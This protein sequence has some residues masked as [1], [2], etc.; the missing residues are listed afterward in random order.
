MQAELSHLK[1]IVWGN[2]TSIQVGVEFFASSYL[3]SCLSRELS[4]TNGSLSCGVS[5]CL[6][7]DA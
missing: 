2:L 5:S 4:D 3:T 1:T 6:M 7:L